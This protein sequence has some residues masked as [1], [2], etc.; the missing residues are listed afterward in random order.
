M[1]TRIVN[2]SD[3]HVGSKAALWPEE[4]TTEAGTVIKA[5]EAQLKLLEYWED[6]WSREAKTAE[7]VLLLG[8]MCEG[9]N[10]RGQARGLMDADLHEQKRAA[11]SLLEPKVKG[12]I[13]RGIWG[14][15]YHTSDDMEIDKMITE[16]LGGVDDGIIANLKLNKTGKIINYSHTVSGAVIY[17]G[18]AIDRDSLFIDAVEGQKLNFHIDLYIRAHWHWYGHQENDSRH[19]VVNPGWKLWAPIRQK[20]AVMWAKFLPTIG[21]TVIDIDDDF[22]FV[23]KYSYPLVAI[24]DKLVKER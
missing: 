22:I 24:Y 10:P 2:I 7:Y 3:L 14:T 11:I 15:C 5:S 4:H 6:F 23:R 8:D 16:E 17:R 21:G 12:K 20:N 1:K 9:K 13:I 19:L 18:M